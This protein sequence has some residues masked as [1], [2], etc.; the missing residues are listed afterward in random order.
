MDEDALARFGREAAL[1]P[2]EVL[3]GTMSACIATSFADR[4]PGV[5]TPTLVVGGAHDPIFTPD[6]LRT[7]MVDAIPRA[8]LALL[9]CSH[10]I[11]LERP[12]ELAAVIEAFLAG[13]D[14]PAASA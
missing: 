4:V 13:L 7:T 14:R 5:S 12:R 9:D 2:R 3:E 8:R 11:P 1:V 6:G 10:E